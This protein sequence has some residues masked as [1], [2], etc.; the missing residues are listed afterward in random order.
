MS[1]PR[2]ISVQTLAGLKDNV[3]NYESHFRTI[4]AVNNLITSLGPGEA[5]KPQN[6]ALGTG[7]G[8]GASIS[9]LSGTFKRGSFLISI[10]S[11]GFTANPSVTLNFP[12]GT[13]ENPFALVMRNGGNGVLPFTYTQSKAGIVITFQGTP[14]AGQAYGFQFDVRD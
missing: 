4:Q 2:K 1:L 10:G 13:F 14:S 6:F 3:H 8:T 7:F 9:A 12:A 5:I 11:G